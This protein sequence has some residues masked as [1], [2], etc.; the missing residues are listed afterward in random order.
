MKTS[1]IR[2]KELAGLIKET[3]DRD[4]IAHFVWSRDELMDQSEDEIDAI[5]DE[6]EQEYNASKANYSTVEDYLEDLEQSGGLEAMLSE[7][8]ST[9]SLKSNIDQRW[10]TADDMAG[11]MQ[12]WLSG[13]YGSGNEDMY[14]EVMNILANLADNFD[15][16]DDL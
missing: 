9:M 1:K 12:Q 16:S 10:K 3:A 15:P 8:Y 14:E 6:L 7:N 5:I 13:I 4:A 2:L 11:D